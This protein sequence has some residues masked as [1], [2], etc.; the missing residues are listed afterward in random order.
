MSLRQV[1]SVQV[2]LS[3][4][5]LLLFSF[6]FPPSFF[7]SWYLLE[8]IYVT[9]HLISAAVFLK[10][11]MSGRLSLACISQRVALYLPSAICSDGAS[12]GMILF[13]NLFA[14]YRLHTQSAAPSRARNNNQLRY[15]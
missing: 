12:R 1:G 6:F 7:N 13:C 2:G 9:L 15:I 4:C 10:L 3:G 14:K 11:L 5:A 8:V